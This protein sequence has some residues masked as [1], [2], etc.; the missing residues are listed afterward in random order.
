MFRR[1]PG[2]HSMK[3]PEPQIGETEDIKEYI[4]AVSKRGDHQR[5]HKPAGASCGLWAE[6][7]RTSS[8]T[9]SL[10]RLDEF[11]STLGFW[12]QLS[13]CSS[14]LDPTCS[15][16]VVKD[17]AE[18]LLGTEGR[19][20]ERRINSSLIPS[21]LSHQLSVKMRIQNDKCGWL[22]QDPRRAEIRKASF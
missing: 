10:T 6:Q 7:L 2:T 8:T 17:G 15:E 21:A 9:P 5:P 1:G 12:S 20:W 11:R 18:V 14:Y 4:W 22:W 13:A 19:H 16:A 3:P